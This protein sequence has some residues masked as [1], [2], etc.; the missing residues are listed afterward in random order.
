MKK[1]NLDRTNLPDTT[2]CC[3]GCGKTAHYLWAEKEWCSLLDDGLHWCSPQCSYEHDGSVADLWPDYMPW[4][5]CPCPS[6]I[7]MHDTISLGPTQHGRTHLTP[8]KNGY[9]FYDYTE[10]II[11]ANRGTRKIPDGDDKVRDALEK[12]IAHVHAF[13]AEYDR[14]SRISAKHTNQ[15]ISKKVLAAPWI[16]G[17]APYFFLMDKP[18]PCPECG[19]L[20]GAPSEWYR[21]VPCSHGCFGGGA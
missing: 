10:C 5:K 15:L 8:P 4:G 7:E 6:C 9:C 1:E 2:V 20:H 21:H 16:D 19:T 14:E 17:V 12:E 18:Q 11:C 13:H 3:V